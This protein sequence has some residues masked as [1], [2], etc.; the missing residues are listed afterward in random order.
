MRSQTKFRLAPLA[1]CVVVAALLGLDATPRFMLG[2]SEAYLMTGKNGVE[3][4]PP[5]RSWIYGLAARGLLLATHGFLAQM[6]LNAAALAAF[7]F[8]AARLI[9]Q[10]RGAA[11]ATL[12]F[13]VAIACDPL[14]E[15]YLR[16]SMSDLPAALL[17][18]GFVCLLA[19]RLAGAPGRA[20]AAASWLGIVVFGAGAVAFRVAYVPIELG[21][22]LLAASAS[23]IPRAG[24]AWSARA[25]AIRPLLLACLV[26]L[27]SVGAIGQLTASSTRNVLA[28]VR[29]STACRACS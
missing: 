29:S 5:D 25:R 9:P 2:D 24:R 17:F 20:A 11:A 16:F 21:T 23:L 4:L 27:A 15:T 3:S 18:A 14:T 26:P 6:L 8:A 13:A 28:T 7:V 1:A 12:A 10:R 22:A 19:G